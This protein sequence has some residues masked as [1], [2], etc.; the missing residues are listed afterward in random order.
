VVDASKFLKNICL[1][2][3]SW[4]DEKNKESIIEIM[5][6]KLNTL[7]HMSES[8]KVK[9]TIIQVTCGST[10]TDYVRL[11]NR[12]DDFSLGDYF[13]EFSNLKKQKSGYN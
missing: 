6:V 8:S 9:K 13:N 1:A 12:S 10:G 5:N 4:D 11:G 2:T 3:A 7:K